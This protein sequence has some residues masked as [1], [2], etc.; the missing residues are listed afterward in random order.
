[1]SRKRRS[2]CIHC[3]GNSTVRSCVRRGG[4]GGGGGGGEVVE[5]V[6]EV[7]G[8]EKEDEVV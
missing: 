4:D 5:A 8:V 3:G 1:M 2:H 7:L 6:E